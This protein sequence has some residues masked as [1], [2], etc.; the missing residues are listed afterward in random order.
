MFQKVA[1]H[2]RESLKEPQLFSEVLGVLTAKSRQIHLSPEAQHYSSEPFPS[3]DFHGRYEFFVVLGGDGSVLSVVKRMKDFS[4]PLLPLSAGTLGFLAEIP[5][6]ELGDALTSI[7]KGRFTYDRR[8]LLKVRHVRADGSHDDYFALN[9]AVV[10]QQAVA[11]MAEVRT[12][13]DGEYLTTHRADGL[14][15]AT[16]TGSTAYSLAAGGPIVYPHFEALILTPISP[17]S[18]T[19]RPLILPGGKTVT[20][21]ADEK[22]RV[23]LMLTIDGQTAVPLAEGDFVEIGVAVPKLSFLRLPEEHFFKTIKRKLHWGKNAG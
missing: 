17:H 5:P 16:P 9:E 1:F 11:R 6:A 13:I 10:S 21:L 15:V 7:E 3:V 14:I 4:T 18:F 12:L 2:V 23:P 8:A 20:V 19:H 22:N